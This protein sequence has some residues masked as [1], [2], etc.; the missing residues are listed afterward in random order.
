MNGI[1]SYYGITVE[2][3][4]NVYNIFIEMNVYISGGS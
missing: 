1:S 3:M 2:Q 4:L